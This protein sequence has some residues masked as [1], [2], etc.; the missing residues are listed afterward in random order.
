MDD[1]RLLVDADIPIA[2]QILQAAHKVDCSFAPLLRRNCTLTAKSYWLLE[3]DG[4]SIGVVGYTDFGHFA[5]IGLMAI[6]PSHQIGGAGSRLLTYALEQLEKRGF[7]SITLYSTDPGL[8]F[9]PKHGFQWSGLSTEWQ[10]RTRILAETNVEVLP[11]NDVS[12]IAAFDAPIFGGNREALFRA[13]MHEFPGR[14]LIACGADGECCGFAFA[15]S[16]VIGPIAAASPEVATA[17]IDAAIGMQFSSTPRVILPEA[18]RD[19]ETVLLNL[20][21]A[22]TRTSRYFFRGEAPR[23]QR[24]KMYGQA[25]YSLG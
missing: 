25:A 1:I 15:Q 20:G 2:D 12:Q 19:G 24:R 5:H 14:A 17:L 8:A 10:L 21:F 23:Q 6:H 9:Y 3:A 18:H 13:L 7:R 22:P 4:H 16:A 11:L